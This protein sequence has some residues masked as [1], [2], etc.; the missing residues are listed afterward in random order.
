MALIEALE[1]IQ[2]RDC[3]SA[4]RGRALKIRKIHRILIRAILRTDPVE[5]AGKSEA[6]GEPKCMDNARGENKRKEKGRAARLKRPAGM[7]FAR[8]E[9][10]F[11]RRVFF[12]RIIKGFL[13]SLN[14]SPPF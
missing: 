5:G 13:L 9:T 4:F 2:R 8:V 6:A 10:G 1:E 7:S 12:R 14:P 3:F 11:G